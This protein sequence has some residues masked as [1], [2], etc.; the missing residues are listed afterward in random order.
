VP[1]ATGKLIICA[2]KMNAAIMPISGTCFSPSDSFVREI[3]MLKVRTV[4]TQQMIEITRLRNPS[5]M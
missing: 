4:I 5:G 3:A 1:P 2:A